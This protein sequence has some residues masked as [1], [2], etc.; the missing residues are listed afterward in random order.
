MPAF[1]QKKKIM[2]I[3]LV[4]IFKNMIYTFFQLEICGHKPK[5]IMKEARDEMF[6]CVVQYIIFPPNLVSRDWLVLILLFAEL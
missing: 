5:A 4:N 2:Y 1:S 3:Y 6:H